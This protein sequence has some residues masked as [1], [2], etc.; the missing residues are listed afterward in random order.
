M[1]TVSK[2]EARK[3]PIRIAVAWRGPSQIDGGPVR[4]VV[5]C[6]DG[7]SLNRKTGPM[8]QVLICRDDMQPYDAIKNG[9]DR[10]VCA[11][12]PLRPASGG[13]C[14]VNLG[15]YF[16]RVWEVSSKL[17]E[18]LERACQAIR[19]SGLTLRLG[20]W[21]DPTA[22]PLDVITALTEAAQGSE[23]RSRHTAY[24]SGWR[25]H[26]EYKDLAMAS[27]MNEAEQT[28]AAAM[29]FRTFRLLTTESSLLP[30]EIVCPAI[31]DKDCR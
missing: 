9:G 2:L 3:P 30:G 18:D 31:A 28:E 24:T 20:S 5:Y 26:V 29:G 8:A 6:L 25:G 11:D 27:V 21:G 10:S 12:C 15:R 13:G 16:P 7:G 19:D 14:Y 22:V 23:R 1:S 4:V 17:P